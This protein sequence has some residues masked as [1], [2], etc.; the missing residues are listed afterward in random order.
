[1]SGVLAQVLVRRGFADPG[2]ARAWLA[3]EDATTSRR[4][5]ASRRRRRSSGATSRTAGGSRSTAT[6][7]STGWRR[8]RSSCAR[9]ASWAPTSA[10]SCRAAPR[11]ATACPPRRSS[12]SPPAARGCSSPS[13]A[14]SPR[15]TRSPRRARR[16]WTSSSP[17]TTALA[18]TACCPTR[19]SSTRRSRGYPCPELCGAGVAHKLARALRDDDAERP[20]DL[21]L[22]ALATV[23][24]CVPLRGENRRLVRAG[25]RA[26]GTTRSGAAG[27]HEGGEGGPARID[28][29][30]IGFRLAPR[31]NAAGRLL[32]RRR[33]PR[34]PAHRGR[35]ARPRDR[36]GA[37]PR[38]RRAPPRRAA[39]PLRGRGQVAEPGERTAYV[40]AGEGWHPGV[41]GIVASR[42]AERHHR[43]CVLVALDGDAGT[44]SGRSIPAFDLLGGLHACAEH[45]ARHGGHRAAAGCQVRGRTSRRSARRSRRTRPR[46]CD[47]R[48]SC[49]RSASTPSSPATSWA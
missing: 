48:T 40:L 7:T 4:S 16:G 43:P 27:A 8:P 22:V 28:A 24:D 47:R 44:G 12:A 37:R 14:G 30:A 36:R 38:E 10:G 5:R 32:P 42:I 9:C 29:R 49:R 31:I 15:S 23:A 39:D 20:E 1:M 25:L 45:L 2:A 3:A 18:P 46:C 19:R 21:D 26:M 6:T 35:R 34:A 11:T 41:I 17:T 33:R 13:T